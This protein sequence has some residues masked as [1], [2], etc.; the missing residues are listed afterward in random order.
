MSLLHSLFP[1][2]R[3]EIVRLLFLDPEEELHLRELARL[4]G[5]AVGALQNEVQKLEELELIST[6]RDGN[7]LYYRANDHH[8]IYPELHGL[9]EKTSGIAERLKEALSN[10][11]GIEFAFLYGS[12]AAGEERAS[13]DLDLMVLGSA[14]LRKVAPK[15]SPVSETIGREIN[16]VGSA[17][18]LG[19]MA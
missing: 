7:R 13:S 15:V 11:E 2:A 4:C 12:M 14:G 17:Y 1:R 8:P 19:A 5:M 10:I 3:A 18:E 16:V 9:A 6:R